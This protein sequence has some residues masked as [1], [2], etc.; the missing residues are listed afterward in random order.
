MVARENSF[1]DMSK[2]L[3]NLTLIQVKRL[4]EIERELNLTDSDY[5]RVFSD[6]SLIKDLENYILL[7]IPNIYS[8]FNEEKIESYLG[9]N[10]GQRRQIEVLIGQRI[11]GKK[12]KKASRVPVAIQDRAA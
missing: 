11:K 7:R 9:K 6:R 12:G 8:V 10:R 1:R 2:Q 3:V 4:L 5:Q